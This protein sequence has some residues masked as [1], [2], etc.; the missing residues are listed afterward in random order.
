MSGKNFM[1]AV[2]IIEMLVGVGVLSPQSKISS[3]AASGW[4]LSI[5]LNLWL[6]EDYDIAVR[7]VNMALRAFALARLSEANEE[8]RGEE[9]LVERRLSAA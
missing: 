3:Y 4:L 6:N 5:A 8:E 7:D 2:G 9:D 1:R